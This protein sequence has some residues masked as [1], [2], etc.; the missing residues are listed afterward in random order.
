MK[1]MNTTQAKPISALL[2]GVDDYKGFDATGRSN[3]KGSR[4]DV[5]LIASYCVHVLGMRP[6]SIVA[7]TMPALTPEELEKLPQLRRIRWGEARRK[8]VI[9]AF[10]DM[11]D[12]T[13]PGP[14]LFSF[15]GHGAALANGEPVICLGDVSPGFANGVLSLKL[16][17]E[18]IAQ[19][20]AKDR[21]VAILD[22]CLAGTPKTN[23]RMQSTSL[24]HD[25]QMESVAN[26]QNSFQM[27][28]RVLLA[29]AP[30]KHAYQVRF[31]N[32]WHGALTAAL[33]TAAEQWRAQHGVSH[34]SY[35]HVLRRTRKTLKALGVRQKIHFQVPAEG[36]VAIRKEPFPGV[37]PGFTRKTPNAEQSYLQLTP[38]YLYSIAV[39]GEI[40]ANVVA[41]GSSMPVYVDG[42]LMPAVTECWFVDPN[43]AKNL[44]EAKSITITSTAL[45]SSYSMAANLSQRFTSVEN[46]P[47][48]GF[49]VPPGAHIFAH[50]TMYVLL[51]TAT[52]G[53]LTQVL[54][55][56]S[57][58]PVGNVF[59]F[60]NAT[61]LVY[62]GSSAP[63]ANYVGSRSL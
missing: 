17:G 52:D 4:N 29:A 8:D 10:E 40:M 30:G 18:R 26:Q 48:G 57:Q 44:D 49:D 59:N 13:N 5:I 33:V 1:Q 24:P 21:L 6:E 62:Q 22:C 25:V 53:K 61:G 38:D 36:W 12:G 3:L 54:W 7:L 19:A 51:T 11:L 39:D 43:V 34:G 16:L 14:L 46:N 63:P 50:E 15:S 45:V 47:W 35:K 58:S 60:G 28:D 31:G 27:S 9:T 42:Q 41:T 37:K 2:I 23:A 20:N 32:I 55:C 56:L